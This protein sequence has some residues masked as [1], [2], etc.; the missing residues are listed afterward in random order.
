[1]AFWHT[2]R[3]DGSDPFGSATKQWPWEDPSLD[4]L[5][6]ALRRMRVLFEFLDKLGV[7]Y[8]C[9]HDRCVSPGP[10]S[11]VLKRSWG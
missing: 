4:P 3:G 7:D 10:P 2:L 6:M 8:W 11:F 1:V 5:E 9:F